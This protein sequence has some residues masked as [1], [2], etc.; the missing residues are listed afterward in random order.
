MKIGID[1]GGSHIGL[2]LVEDDGKIIS[3]NDILI[4]QEDKKNI[5][6]IIENYIITQVKKLQNFRKYN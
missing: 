5:T 6:D 4:L 3:K 2:G 1:M